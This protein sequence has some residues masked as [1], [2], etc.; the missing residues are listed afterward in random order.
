MYARVALGFC[1]GSH[2]VAV[3]DARDALGP[4]VA[5]GRVDQPQS[6]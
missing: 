5:Q 1:S 4:H 3:A 2:C 6:K